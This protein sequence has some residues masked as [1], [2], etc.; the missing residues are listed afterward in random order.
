MSPAGGRVSVVTPATAR[1]SASGALHA[2][3]AA[4]CWGAAT[5]MSK[6]ALGHFAP[7][8]LLV[9]QLTVSVVCLWGVIWYRRV[10]PGSSR[11]MLRVAWLGLFEPGLAYMLGL[12]GL[13]GAGAAEAML[14]QSSEG[15][16][17]V[18]VSVVLF[19]QRPT[20][21]FLLL[22]VLALAGLVVALD[23]SVP[24]IGVEQGVGAKLLI[25]AA[26][27]VAALYVM[28]SGRIAD[29]AKA[30]VIVAWQQSVALGFAL[31]VLAVALL[32]DPAARVLPGDLLSWLIAGGSGAVQ[33][34]LAFTFYMQALRSIPANTAGAF[35]TLT[36][37]F[38]L[39]GAYVFLQEALSP[40]QL[41]GAAATLFFVWRISCEETPL[42]R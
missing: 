28:L 6:S 10:A 2:I 34:A 8:P 21:R 41:I 35:L 39:A 14:I 24:I 25:L 22:S 18:L 32:L 20:G 12:W 5:V 3:L 7:I 33:Y 4:V 27:L 42:T 13:A 36:P 40:T 31:V 26:T 1:M 23:L 11:A 37:V 30:I 9:V 19:G 17:I 38:G 16:M 15:L 29:E